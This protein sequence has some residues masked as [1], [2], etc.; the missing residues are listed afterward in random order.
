MI[1]TK[2]IWFLHYHKPDKKHKSN[3][4]KSQIVC[5]LIISEYV[6]LKDS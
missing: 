4:S 2:Y 6:G 5:I 3:Y 1:S